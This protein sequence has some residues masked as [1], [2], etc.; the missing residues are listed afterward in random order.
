[1]TACRYPRSRNEPYI[2]LATPTSKRSPDLVSLRLGKTSA[3]IQ[4][5]VRS[6]FQDYLCN[7]TIRRD[8]RRVLRDHEEK[9]IDT[10]EQ[11]LAKA[12]PMLEQARPHLSNSN[13]EA[14]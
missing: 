8:N 3:G 5:V 14:R 6:C 13:P 4:S 1:M 10:L 12:A 7:T 2:S 9:S 11:P